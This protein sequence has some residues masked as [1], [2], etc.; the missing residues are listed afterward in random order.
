MVQLH[1][2]YRGES[3]RPRK[4]SSNAGGVKIASDDG[5]HCVL[6]DMFIQSWICVCSIRTK[7]SCVEL[8]TSV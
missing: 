8:Q 6:L 3:A 4:D 2:P 1:V 7:K 5:M